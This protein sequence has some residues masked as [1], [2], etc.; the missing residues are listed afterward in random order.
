MRKEA[1]EA[2]ELKRSY[3]SR[4]TGERFGKNYKNYS[5]AVQST[6][7]KNFVESESFQKDLKSEQKDKWFEAIK[8]EMETSN[9]SKF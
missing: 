3:R 7:T 8:A 6:I 5:Y 4:A 1:A 2:R 9:E